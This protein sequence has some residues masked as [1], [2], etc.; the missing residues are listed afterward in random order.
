MISINLLQ[1]IPNKIVREIYRFFHPCIWKKQMQINGIP[2]ITNLRNVEFGMFVSVNSKVFIQ[3]S[4]KVSIGD[5]VTLS[6]GV[7]IF[8]EELDTSQ[9]II[10]AQ[11]KYRD[12]VL[13]SVCIGNG[14]WIAAGAIICPGVKIAANCVVAAGAVV[15]N[16]L[17]NEG[18]LYG[19][20]PAR[21]IKEI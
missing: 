13:N 10:N 17:N 1:R 21:K 16:D 19:G 8:T 5:R 11:K 14:T 7:H 12:H 15:V 9:Y 3:S 4:G 20:V 18:C 2:R 6:R